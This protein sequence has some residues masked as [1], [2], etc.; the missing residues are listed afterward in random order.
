[1][2]KYKKLKELS[3]A[4]LLRNEGKFL[5]ALEIIKRIEKKED[6]T[7]QDQL[8]SHVLKCTFLNKLG[9]HEDALKLAEKTYKEADKLGNPL[10]LIDVSIEMAEALMY[11]VRFNESLEIIVKTE[12]LFKTFSLETTID[13]TRVESSIALIKGYIIVDNYME[14]QDLERSLKILKYGLALQKKLDNKHEIARFYQYIGRCVYSLG[15]WNL[16]LDYW[17]KALKLEENGFNVHLSWLLFFFGLIYRNRGE[18]D[19][20]LNYYNQGLALVEKLNSNGLPIAYLSNVIGEIY[21]MKGDF[22]Q[23]SIFMERGLTLYRQIGHN[24][25]FLVETFLESSLKLAIS[26]NEIKQAEKYLQEIK[27]I[28]D[29]TENKAVDR[30]FSLSKA[31]IL[32]TSPRFRNKIKAEEILKHLLKEKNLSFKFEVDTLIHLCDLLLTELQATNELEVLEEIKPIITRLLDIAER[33]NSY[34]FLCETHLLQAKLSLINFNIKNAKRFLT[35][36]QQIAER[37]NLNQVA[38]KIANEND[39]LLKK[40]YRWEKL[41]E[42]R[43]PMS[44]RMELARM[45]EQI[46]GMVQKGV[47]LTLQV[48]EEK[49]TIHKEKKICLVCRGE[50]LRFSYICECGAIYCENCA[51]ALTNLENVCW[52]CNVPIDYS[53]P[54]KPYKE[55][56][57]IV[58]VDKKHRKNK[59]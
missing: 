30:L 25:L 52:A 32:K 45:G 12:S 31:L 59:V 13:R 50:V 2:E 49:V 1:M 54:V 40:L 38:I 57:E 35:Q 15:D 4:E 53:K 3:N 46:E 20:A 43:A 8:S 28:S 29:Q 21:H 44:E 23:A 37:L 7:P 55:K 26:K 34:W 19:H 14:K 6:L 5:E 33:S 36:A 58:M 11:L 42:F 56:D 17:E 16:A 10:K 39:D 48:T 22:D 9:F 27:E 51:R 47:V 18:L 24:L 41:K